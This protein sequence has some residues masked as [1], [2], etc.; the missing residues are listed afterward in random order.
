M[1]HPILK[2]VLKK[3]LKVVQI[4]KIHFLKNMI[5]QSNTLSNNKTM[6]LNRVIICDIKITL[7]GFIYYS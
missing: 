1:S 7:I 6:T 4:Y 3:D 5:T 2:S